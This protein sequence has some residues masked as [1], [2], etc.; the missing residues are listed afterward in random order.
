MANWQENFAQTASFVGRTL[1]SELQQSIHAYVDG[2]LA[3]N[4]SPLERRVQQGR[5]REGHGDLHAGSVYASTAVFVRL[6]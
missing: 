5:I 1:D 3:A 2:F 6:H 4:Q